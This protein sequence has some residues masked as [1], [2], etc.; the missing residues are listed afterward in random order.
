MPSRIEKAS[1]RDFAQLDERYTLAK[2]TDKLAVFSQGILAM[3]KTFIGVI[4]LTLCYNPG[5]WRIY[6]ESTWS[7]DL[8]CKNCKIGS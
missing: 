8:G 4:E 5:S 2:A 6:K 1:F 3:S 7:L